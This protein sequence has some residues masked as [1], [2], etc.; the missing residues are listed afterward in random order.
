MVATAHRRCY[1]HWA[2]AHQPLSWHCKAP[3]TLHLFLLTTPQNS[4]VLFR[5]TQGL[6]RDGLQKQRT[7]PRPHINSDIALQDL[8]W[9]PSIYLRVP[10]F[11]SCNSQA[12]VGTARLWAILLII[13]TAPRE[14]RCAQPCNGM[15][16]NAGWHRPTPQ[17]HSQ[18][19]GCALGWRQRGLSAAPWGSVPTWDT[20][21]LQPYGSISSGKRFPTQPGDVS[22]P[23][24]PHTTTDGH[25]SIT[26]HSTHPS[27][28]PSG[29][30]PTRVPSHPTRTTHVSHQPH[31]AIPAAL[32]H[33]AHA[34]PAAVPRAPR[35]PQAQLHP[36]PTHVC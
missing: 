2:P 25:S 15:G 20:I 8:E 18:E 32:R 11:S 30:A 6:Q 7:N 29:T 14:P 9:S 36:R 22:S 1:T 26:T 23:Q 13:T 34:H 10:S 16:R 19:E 5:D 35:S 4:A 33:P 17:S 27:T 12:F 24:Q 3:A 21:I 31:N 28:T